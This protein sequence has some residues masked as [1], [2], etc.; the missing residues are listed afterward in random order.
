MIVCL[1]HRV[2]EAQIASRAREGCGSFD[3][4]QDDL[5]VATACGAC[6]ECALS[7]F[8]A[9]CGAGPRGC[10][11]AALRDHRFGSPLAA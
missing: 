7:T 1:C 2:T 5:R 8:E 6:K 10:R 4:L 11:G 9:A 3:E